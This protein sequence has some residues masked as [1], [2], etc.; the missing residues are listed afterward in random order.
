MDIMSRNTPSAITVA[1]YLLEKAREQK[2][3]LTPLHLLKLVYI[4]HGWSL[5]ILGRDLVAEEV[6]AWQYGPVIPELY[7]RIKSYGA[8]PVARIDRDLDDSPVELDSIEKTLIEKVFES[9]KHLSA[10]QLSGLTHKVG[11][12]WHQIWKKHGRNSVIPTAL[13][14]SHYTELARQQ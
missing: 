6:Y 7:H 13:I 4:C 3:S 12:P 2:R 5:A 10:I 14:R 1:N 9:Y 8:N 11:T